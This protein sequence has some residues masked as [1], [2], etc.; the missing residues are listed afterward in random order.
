MLSEPAVKSAIEHDPLPGLLARRW[1]GIALHRTGDPARA[2][3]LLTASAFAYGEALD[4]SLGFAVDVSL[5]HDHAERARQGAPDPEG[6]S[7]VL[8]RLAKFEAVAAR[9]ERKVATARR[10][11]RTPSAL[12]RA[13]DALALAAGR[14]A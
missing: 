4:P 2:S 13:L 7:I 1:L 6:V 8:D 5:V 10:A 11:A 3:T 9:L 14:L 12:A